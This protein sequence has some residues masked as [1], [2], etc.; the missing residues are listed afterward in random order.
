ME[1]QGFFGNAVDGCGIAERTGGAEQGVEG[2]A[3]RVGAE[4]GR[5]DAQYCPL[6]TA[7]SGVSR[8]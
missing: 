2:I 1:M 8:Q 4:G 7:V 6:K 3:V 5:T